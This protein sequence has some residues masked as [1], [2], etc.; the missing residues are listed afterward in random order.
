MRGSGLAETSK[1]YLVKD[2]VTILGGD[3]YPCAVYAREGGSSIG[4]F[5]TYNEQLR[6]TWFQQH[7]SHKD[8]ICKKFCMDFKCRYNDKAALQEKAIKDATSTRPPQ[9]T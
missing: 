4:R 3:V 7:N 1:C 8:P 5:T 6:Y 9:Q 2:D